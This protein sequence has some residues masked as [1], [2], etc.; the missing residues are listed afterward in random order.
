MRIQSRAFLQLLAFV[1]AIVIILFPTLLFFI[2]T[3]EANQ[4]SV[5]P[6]EME[7][8]LIRTLIW[9][10]SVGICSTSIGWFVGLR[11]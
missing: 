9:S 7:W 6:R 5:L 4:H 1:I 2:T 8:I 11:I 3:T 10:L